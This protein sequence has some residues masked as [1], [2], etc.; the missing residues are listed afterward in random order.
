MKAWQ[1]DILMAD[2]IAATAW[3]F[4]LNRL[5][6]NPYKTIL[7][8]LYNVRTL[9]NAVL[10]FLCNCS[11]ILVQLHVCICGSAKTRLILFSIRVKIS[12]QNDEKQKFNVSYAKTLQL[13]YIG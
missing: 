9:I 2:E 13:Y 10:L 4:L 3:I 7:I 6:H 5:T 1:I 12:Q 8:Q 11:A